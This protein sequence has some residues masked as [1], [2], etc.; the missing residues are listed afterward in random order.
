MKYRRGN[1]A[2][3]PGGR[4]IGHFATLASMRRSP[5]HRACPDA[6]FPIPRRQPLPHHRR[7]WPAVQPTV[8][9]R[10]SPPHGN[11]LIEL[12]HGPVQHGQAVP[13][14]DGVG[15]V[16]P[17]LGGADRQHLL[18]Q[19]FGQC[20]LP[21]RLVQR[22]QLYWVSMVSRWSA[23]SLA[24]RTASTSWY[25]VSAK[26][27]FACPGIARPNRTWWRRYRGGRPPAWRCGSPAPPCTLPRPGRSSLAKGTA[28]PNHAGC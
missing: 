13:A 17:Q 27:Y 7:Q 20:V 24:V 8:P 15:V 19:R 10:A 14:E 22:G 25:S 23:P 18:V 5:R 28:W 4:V 9:S 16:G 26:S 21:L 11:R 2:T 12:L 6:D 3:R 1:Y